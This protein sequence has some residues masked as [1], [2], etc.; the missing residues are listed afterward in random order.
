MLPVS[1]LQ[2]ADHHAKQLLKALTRVAALALN[3][4]H[5]MH[6]VLLQA[7]ADRGNSAK[8]FRVSEVW[9]KA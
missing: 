3:R 7:A 8:A 2:L 9:L 5:L 1:M 6:E 4:A